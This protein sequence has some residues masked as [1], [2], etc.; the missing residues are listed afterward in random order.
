MY[1]LHLEGPCSQLSSSELVQELVKRRNGIRKT[2][3]FPS[4]SNHD[5]RLAACI[6]GITRKNL[7]V[8]EDA[9]WER[10]SSS[11]SPEVSSEP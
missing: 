6:I 1:N 2:L 10:L 4:F 8:I 3:P 9:L 7:P 5:P 11:V